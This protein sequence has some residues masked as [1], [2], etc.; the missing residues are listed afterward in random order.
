MLLPPDYRYEEN[1]MKKV[2]GVIDFIAGMMDTFAIEK[3][4][5]LFGI[6]FNEI[7]HSSRF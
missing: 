5:E 6:K 7:P 3:Y 4:E 1:P 2:K